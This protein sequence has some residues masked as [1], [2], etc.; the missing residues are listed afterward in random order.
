[1]NKY[2]KQF[3]HN[4]TTTEWAINCARWTSKWVGD[5]K[6]KEVFKKRERKIKNTKNYIGSPFLKDYI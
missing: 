6:Y 1:M 4:I 5:N 2:K 3:Q